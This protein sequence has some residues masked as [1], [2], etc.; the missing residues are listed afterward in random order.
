MS[1]TLSFIDILNII[2]RCSLNT[3]P[4]NQYMLEIIDNMIMDACANP[5]AGSEDDTLKR[6]FNGSNPFPRDKALIIYSHKDETK[7]ASFLREMGDE[8]IYNIEMEIQ[9]SEPDYELDETCYNLQQLIYLRLKE[10]AN[11]PRK[12]RTGKSNPPTIPENSDNSLSVIEYALVIGEWEET[13]RID[14]MFVEAL[15]GMDYK[16]FSNTLIKEKDMVEVNYPMWAVKDREERVADLCLRLRDED[17]RHICDS[18]CNCVFHGNGCSARLMNSISVLIS[19][20]SNSSNTLF[21]RRTYNGYLCKML[22]QL[23]GVIDS[24]P[25]C[26]EVSV[27]PLLSEINYSYF[28]SIVTGPSIINNISSVDDVNKYCYQAVLLKASEYANSALTERR[29]R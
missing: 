20:F 21:S 18:I 11:K 6:I 25:N 5:I 7:L 15:V 28:I 23:T 16:S 9:S 22:E 4:K 12:K 27:L 3:K 14:T 26:N 2:T 10:I 8:V 19:I 29:F 1:E 17:I 24:N 13:N